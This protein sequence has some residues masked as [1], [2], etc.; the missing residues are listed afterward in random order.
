MFV[1]NKNIHRLH[2]TQSNQGK[3]KLAGNFSKSIGKKL[4]Q[5]LNLWIKNGR[6]PHAVN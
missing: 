4:Y 1:D 3:K 6:T 2:L 5:T